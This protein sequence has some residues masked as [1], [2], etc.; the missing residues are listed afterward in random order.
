VKSLCWDLSSVVLKTSVSV[1]GSGTSL[2]IKHTV[3]E[4]RNI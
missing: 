2:T 1:F 4:S 3:E